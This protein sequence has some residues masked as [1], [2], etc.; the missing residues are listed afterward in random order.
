MQ[1]PMS[2]FNPLFTIGRHFEET[3]RAHTGMTG[4][5]SRA[6]AMD[7][8][9]RVG[10]SRPAVI[11]TQY[12]F[13]LSG[14]MLQR[15]M[16][17]MAM[18][19]QPAVLIADEPTTALD[20]TVRRQILGQLSRL[21]EEYRTAMLLVSHDL[22]VIAQLADQVAVMYCGYIVEK[23][24]VLELF[25]SPAHP[26]TRA[27]MASRPDLQRKRLHPVA[28]QPPSLLNLPR[29]CPFSP[30]CP[31]ASPLCVS[32]DMEPV[33]RGRDHLVRCA[34]YLEKR[35]AVLDEPA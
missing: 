4:T 27:L 29:G 8:L 1:N 16:I 17:A 26:Y 10:L 9:D 28:G 12:P 2:A 31:D 6:K 14:G 7:L 33:Q 3:L 5:Q 11:M 25:D 34:A 18:S 20:A 23:A 19:M 15:V 32:Y 30:R 13:Q 21:R 35:G 24:P 22:G